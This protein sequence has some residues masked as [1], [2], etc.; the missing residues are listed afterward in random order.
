M[1]QRQPSLH[2]E[3]LAGHRQANAAMVPLEERKS[4]QN[5][6]P[7]ARDKNQTVPTGRGVLAYRSSEPHKIRETIGLVVPGNQLEDPLLRQLRFL[8]FVNTV[9]APRRFCQR[10]RPTD[11]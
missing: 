4:G 5:L 6:C 1:K 9:G 11:G 10:P 7:R 8:M 3:R 2:H